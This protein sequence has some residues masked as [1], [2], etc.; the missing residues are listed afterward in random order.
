VN[1]Y[2]PYGATELDPFGDHFV[3]PGNGQGF[4]IG[5]SFVPVNKVTVFGTYLSGGNVS[6]NQSLQEFDGGIAYQFAPGARIT[7]RYRELRLH[8]VEQDQLFRAQVD[9]TF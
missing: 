7:L 5:L 9:Y 4:T 3:Y 6:N 1:F 2:P 8:G